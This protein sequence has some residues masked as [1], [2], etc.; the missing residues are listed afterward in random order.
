VRF[1]GEHLRPAAGESRKVDRLLA[2]LDSDD[3][4]VRE[5]A[6]AALA[7]LGEA[8]E[9]ALRKALE[10]EPSPEVR[11]RVEALMQ[12]LHSR[13]LSAEEARALRAVEALEYCE[14]PEARRLLQALGTGA[15]EARLT[16]EARAALGRLSR[17]DKGR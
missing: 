12:K 6:S 3:F 8:A 10:G 16:R 2:D 17:P 4:P 9:P 11:R 13:S 15:P 7:A 14:T 5:R 1:L